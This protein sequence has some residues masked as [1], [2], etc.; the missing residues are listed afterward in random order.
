MFR[1]LDTGY[2]DT[3][4]HE[5][6]V[7]RGFVSISNVSKPK[8]EGCTDN[9]PNPTPPESGGTDSG[10]S[11]RPQRPVVDIGEVNRRL[12]EAAEAGGDAW[13]DFA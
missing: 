12:A 9:S 7:L 4:L 2:V 13:V 5:K 8:T 3:K 1:L 6:A 10:Q 11:G